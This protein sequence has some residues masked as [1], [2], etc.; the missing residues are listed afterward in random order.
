MSIPTKP[1]VLD[2]TKGMLNKDL[3]VVT[4]TPNGDMGA[5]MENLKEHLEFLVELEKQGILFGAGP[6][7]ADDEHTWHGEGMIILRAD[8]LEAAR[9][10]AAADPMH[11]S[12]ARSFTVRAWMLNEGSITI[13]VG[14]AQGTRD[15]I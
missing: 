12:G 6:F 10:L 4:T 5:V 3:Y 2:A 1:D 13:K 11:S 15:V 14:Y 8:N 7:W 9:K